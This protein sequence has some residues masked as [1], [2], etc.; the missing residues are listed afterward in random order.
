MLKAIKNHFKKYNDM[1]KT[2]D[3]LAGHISRKLDNVA[4]FGQEQLKFLANSKM[5]GL[6]EAELNTIM[7]EAFSKV[8]FNTKLKV[9][10]VDQAIYLKLKKG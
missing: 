8:I 9:E 7:K 10:K 2:A 3:Y 4:M 5:E 1:A 6:T